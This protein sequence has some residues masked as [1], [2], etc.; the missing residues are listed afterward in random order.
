ML[1][2]GFR[3][4]RGGDLIGGKTCHENDARIIMPRVMKKYMTYE[5]NWMKNEKKRT[6]KNSF[7]IEE[8]NSARKK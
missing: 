6:L 8:W 1:W 4:K 3:V 5:S 7:F 2:D